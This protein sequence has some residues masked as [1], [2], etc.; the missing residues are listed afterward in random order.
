MKKT[1]NCILLAFLLLVPFAATPVYSLGL[2]DDIEDAAEAMY[3]WTRTDTSLWHMMAEFCDYYPKRLSGSDNLERGIDWVIATMR[4]RGWDVRTQNV[5]VPSWKRG[6]EW[7]KMHGVLEK[8]MKIAGLGGSVS[9]GVAPLVAEVYVVNSFDDLK[10]H[11]EEVKGKIVVWNVEFTTYGETVA[12][13][14]GGA[15]EAARYGAVASLVRSIG[16]FGM[17]TPHTGGMK[18]NDS[19]PKIPAAAISMEDAL[20]LQ[21]M[22]DRKV[23]IELELMLVS[24]WASDANSRNVI[25]E[26]KGTTH[27]E[28]IVVMGG[29]IDSWDLGTGAMDDAG[30]CFVA[31]RALEMMRDLGLKPRR[32]IRLCLW[33]N[34]ENGTRGAQAYADSTKNE[35]H[36][37]GIESDGGTF[38][39]RGFSGTLPPDM[40]EDLLDAFEH[41]EIIGAS[42]I[43]DGDGGAD[44]GPLR[45]KG[46]PVME[47]E[48]DISRY[49]WYHHTEADTPDKLNPKE[50]NDCTYAMA[51]AAWACAN[52]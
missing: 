6:N 11:A 23:K 31:W 12:Y 2:G 46:I 19:L 47:L 16:P 38:R 29:H 48:V 49:F 22:Q 1:C 20:L 24:S 4:A 26:L 5:S 28:E 44:T 33:T 39:P 27:P 51:L 41:L 14:Y 35:H 30:G 8:E 10:T 21:R 13:R 3:K 42:E 25:I 43:R 50:M 52:R 45:E 32:T 37:A 40:K 15:S 9:T 7:L 17:Q 36:V 34:E 18:Y